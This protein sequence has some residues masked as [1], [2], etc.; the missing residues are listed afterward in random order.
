MTRYGRRSDT[1]VIMP[2]AW[3]ARRPPLIPSS[4]RLLEPDTR[5]QAG[6]PS[7]RPTKPS[8]RVVIWAA[9]SPLIACVASTH[10]SACPSGS[11]VV[12]RSNVWVP[13]TVHTALDL[14]LRR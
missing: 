9:N 6:T 12:A 14:L 10:S 11:S 4:R 5:V 1:S 13:E 8:T 7:T 3:K 2:S